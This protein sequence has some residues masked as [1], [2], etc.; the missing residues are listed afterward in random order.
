M[1]EGR[2]QILILRSLNRRNLQDS[3]HERVLNHLLNIEDF[4]QAEK[5]AEELI[6]II[7]DPMNIEAD[8]IAYLDE[9]E[10]QRL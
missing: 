10:K 3:T 9:L 4:E 2:A 1:K 5:R 7:D 8:I 6:G